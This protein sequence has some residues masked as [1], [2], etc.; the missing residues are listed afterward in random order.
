M[1]GYNLGA[2]KVKYCR[3]FSAHSGGFW[4][5]TTCRFVDDLINEG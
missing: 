1:T 2:A 4:E 3:I 5:I